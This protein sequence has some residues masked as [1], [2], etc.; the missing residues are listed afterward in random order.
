MRSFSFFLLCS[1]PVV[2]PRENVCRNRKR[3]ADA[4]PLVARPAPER[5]AGRAGDQ[6]EARNGEAGE[7]SLQPNP[8]Q[9]SEGSLSSHWIFERNTPKFFFRSNLLNS[10]TG[11]LKFI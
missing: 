10:R 1:F 5:R 4:S 11:K 7:P 9:A 8:S 6:S 3:L 2:L